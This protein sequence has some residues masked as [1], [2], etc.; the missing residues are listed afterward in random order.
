M[1][2]TLSFDATQPLLKELTTFGVSHKLDTTNKSFDHE[3]DTKVRK[4]QLNAVTIFHNNFDKFIK[5][6][7]QVVVLDIIKEIQVGQFVS[8]HSLIFT[9]DEHNIVT[10][11]A[12]YK[13]IDTD[14]FKA[15]K[16]TAR[17]LAQLRIAGLA[18]MV[19]NEDG[20]RIDSYLFG[21]KLVEY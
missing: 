4:L 19:P 20:T 15:L 14:C 3:I 13:F 11:S 5:D 18:E 9:L 1:N 7:V 16:V 12:T 2:I 10:V 17:E 8:V 21:R 6:S